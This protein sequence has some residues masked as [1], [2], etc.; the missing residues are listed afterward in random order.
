M[1]IFGAVLLLGVLLFVAAAVY[2]FVFFLLWNDFVVTH[3]AGAAHVSFGAA[4]LVG[5]GLAFL[6]QGSRAPVPGI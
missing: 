2:G 3:L 6:F 4:M 1:E 5:I